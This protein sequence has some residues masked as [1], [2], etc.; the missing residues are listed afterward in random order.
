MYDKILYD[1]RVYVFVSVCLCLSVQVV[2]FLL[3]NIVNLLVDS[4]EI[5]VLLP[6]IVAVYAN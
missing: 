4:F 2:D 6:L 1:T 5:K 3:I